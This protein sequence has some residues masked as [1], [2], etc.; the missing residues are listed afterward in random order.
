MYK[1]SRQHR[2]CQG[3]V[4]SCK[5]LKDPAMQT[6]TTDHM[7]Y[8]PYTAWLWSVLDHAAATSFE[9]THLLLK[10]HKKSRHAD[11]TDLLHI[12]WLKAAKARLMF[13]RMSL[14]GSLEILM[15]VCK[16]DSGTILACRYPRRVSP[17]T[18]QVRM[19]STVQIAKTQL[20]KN[21]A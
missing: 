3:S 9:C 17:G 2:G 15:Q 14:G 21:I 13:E 20:A 8:A 1:H 11:K 16:M 12:S 5:L 6:D 4:C 7:A 18:G 19:K 10:T